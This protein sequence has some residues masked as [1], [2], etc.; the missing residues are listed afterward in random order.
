MV[1]KAP[2]EAEE[3]LLTANKSYEI[4]LENIASNPS[5]YISSLGNLIDAL[6]GVRQY[7]SA[8]AMRRQMVGDYLNL[9]PEKL[10]P[11]ACEEALNAFAVLIED[12]EIN[13]NDL[14][15]YLKRTTAIIE[16]YDSDDF[17]VNKALDAVMKNTTKNYGAHL[18]I[19]FTEQWLKLRVKVRGDKHPSLFHIMNKLVSLYEIVGD[20]KKSRYHMECIAKL[21]TSDQKTYIKRQ[22]KLAEFYFQHSLLNEGEKAWKEAGKS[23]NWIL[24]KKTVYLFEDLIENL[25]EWGYHQQVEKIS[26]MLLEHPNEEILATLDTRLKKRLTQLINSSDLDAAEKLVTHRVK[27]GRA[28]AKS[29]PGSFWQLRLSEIYAATGKFKKSSDIFQ[30]VLGAYALANIT[31]A[32]IKVER[33]NLFRRLGIDSKGN[34]IREEDSH[35]EFL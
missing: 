6:E 29:D 14:L 31:T 30:Q 33:A 7:D 9:P 27:A 11:K 25:E 8:S 12:K 20:L 21:P 2:Q 26:D 22:L 15:D 32:G 28:V 17:D 5:G 1:K 19:P 35:I 34:K 3:I 4:A 10:G 18:E 16:Q 24:P 13:S 23:V